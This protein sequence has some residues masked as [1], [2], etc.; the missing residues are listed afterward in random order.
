MPLQLQDIPIGHPMFA[1]RAICN[2]GTRLV[3]APFH[4]DHFCSGERPSAD[5]SQQNSSKR[6]ASED[7]E[8]SK[9]KRKKKKTKTPSGNGGIVINLVE[10]GNAS[11]TATALS[12][13]TV[14][15]VFINNSSH[16]SLLA[17]RLSTG[18]VWQSSGPSITS[19]IGINLCVDII[20]SFWLNFF[21]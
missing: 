18:R 2:I 12:T 10:E 3:S 13:P 9:R 5:A 8:E 21:K 15:L 7:G 16:F 19:S 11:T 1:R 17:S 20:D 4:S 14:S 6:K